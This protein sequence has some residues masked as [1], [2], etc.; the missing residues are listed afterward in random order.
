M[1]IEEKIKD[2]KWRN[3]FKGMGGLYWWKKEGKSLEI[4]GQVQ[5]RAINAPAMSDLIQVEGTEKCRETLKIILVVKKTC[6][7]RK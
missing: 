3:L 7:L 4:V 5:I 1:D 6:K 2:T